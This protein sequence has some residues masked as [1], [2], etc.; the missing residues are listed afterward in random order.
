MFVWTHVDMVGI[1]PEV[2]YHWLNIDP[3]VKLV[4]HKQRALDL[5]RY[6]A[7]QDVVDRLLK[8]GFIRDTYYPD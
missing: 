6:K 5:N 7:L 8:I 3:Q 4:S 2:M 1:H